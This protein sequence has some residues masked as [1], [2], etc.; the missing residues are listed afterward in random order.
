MHFPSPDLGT[1]GRSDESVPSKTYAEH[2]QRQDAKK[3]VGAPVRRLD[4]R[5][6][7]CTIDIRRNKAVASTPLL[8]RSDARQGSVGSLLGR[9]CSLDCHALGR[10]LCLITTP[11][12]LSMFIRDM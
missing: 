1:P 9:D 3:H 12:V 6:Q 2:D 4:C 10:F 11:E 7:F 5:Q 8:G